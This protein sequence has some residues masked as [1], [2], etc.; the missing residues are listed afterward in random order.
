MTLLDEREARQQA[1][2]H[3]QLAR[4]NAAPETGTNAERGYAILISLTL[5]VVNITL[6]T[7]ARAQYGQE[8][9]LSEVLFESLKTLPVFVIL[10]YI[11][12]PFSSLVRRS[13]GFVA[14]TFCGCYIVTLFN[15]EGYY[16]SMS[17][18][19]AI[20]TIWV[21]LF[22]ELDWYLDA[23]TLAVT[24]AYTYMRDFSLT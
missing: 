5:L 3:S 24:Y 16:A 15:E 6:S 10:I 11:C 17:K 23:A 4:P 20:G 9:V 19:P 8:V 13:L 7:L 18:V 21:W 22:I 1:R 2:G 12:H 14:S